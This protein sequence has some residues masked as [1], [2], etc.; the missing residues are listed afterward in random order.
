M[1]SA[2]GAAGQA[3][4]REGGHLLVRGPAVGAV[5]RGGAPWEEPASSQVRATFPKPNFLGEPCCSLMYKT[6][7]DLH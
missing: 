3:V 5:C 2:R 7:A 1:G 4:H 6:H